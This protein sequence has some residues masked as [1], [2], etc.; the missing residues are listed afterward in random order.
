MNFHESDMAPGKARVNWA[1]MEHNVRTGEE[2][3]TGD[4]PFTT[5]DLGEDKTLPA[6][7]LPISM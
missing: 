5:G 2:W 4:K 7:S 1:H 3:G 6:F